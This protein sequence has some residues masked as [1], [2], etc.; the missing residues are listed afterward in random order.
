[1]LT[2][3]GGATLDCVINTLCTAVLAVTGATVG[4]IAA[5]EGA[6]TADVS[7]STT[8]VFAAGTGAG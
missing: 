3:A 4:M 6:G 2:W 7:M 5:G 1:M 8:A